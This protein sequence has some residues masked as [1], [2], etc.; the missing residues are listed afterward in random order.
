LKRYLALIYGFLAYLFF[1][2]V[3]LY[4]IGFVGNLWVLKSIDRNETVRVAEAFWMDMLLLALFGVQHSVMARPWFKKRWTRIIAK[5]VERSTFV[6]ISSLVLALLF[7]Q[8]RPIPAVVWQIADPAGRMLVWGLFWFGWLLMLY[9]SFTIDHFDLFGLRQVILYFRAIPYTRVNFKESF[10]Y[11]HVRHPIMIGF[12]IAFWATPEMTAGHMLFAFWTTVYI[13][14][15]IFLEER[16]LSR[17]LGA[18]YRE[19]RKRVPM[20][21]PRWRKKS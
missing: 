8:W 5:P 18:D 4:A 14:V 12:I 11:N 15:G 7:W 9:S 20:L 13:L 19:Y 2:A 16:D 6:L 10:P 1:L 21:V 3:I 17:F